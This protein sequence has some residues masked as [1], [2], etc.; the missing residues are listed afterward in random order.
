[1]EQA[2]DLE[3]LIGT[4]PE[5]T[6]AARLRALMPIIDQRI[7]DGVSHQDVVDA[8]NAHGGLATKVK[9]QTFRSYLFRYR[10]KAR[11]ARA[12]GGAQG[13][14]TAAQGAPAT[15]LASMAARNPSDL[16]RLRNEEVDLDELSRIGK[17]KRGE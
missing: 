6:L 12:D 3:A 4:I 15:P 13:A 8:L 9:L 5:T 7:K 1:M 16:K 2:V 10:K 17:N 11:T 14:R